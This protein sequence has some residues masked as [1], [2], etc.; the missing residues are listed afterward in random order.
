MIPQKHRNDNEMSDLQR[1]AA[2]EA[3]VMKTGKDLARV[4]GLVRLGDLKVTRGR[5]ASGVPQPY[6]ADLPEKPMGA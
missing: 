2:L 1:I 4:D 6:A 3:I 5:D